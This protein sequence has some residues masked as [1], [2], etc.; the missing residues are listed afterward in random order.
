M[1]MMDLH[2]VSCWAMEATQNSTNFV[3]P[4]QLANCLLMNLSFQLHE[5]HST[6]ATVNPHSHAT[7]GPS[8]R[9]V[10]PQAFL[11]LLL[12]HQLPSLSNIIS[13]FFSCF[14]FLI[15]NISGS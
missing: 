11:P 3:D 1:W 14:F 6:I 4:H 10:R 8:L 15:S 9:S 13:N 2:A 12:F 5:F 7:A